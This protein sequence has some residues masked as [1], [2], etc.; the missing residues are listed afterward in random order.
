MPN[1]T[2]LACLFESPHPEL[3]F[4]VKGLEVILHDPDT[5]Q[6]LPSMK[7]L[8]IKTL[9]IGFRSQ[10]DTLE[11]MNQMKGLIASHL[12]D[13]SSSNPIY[14]YS[15]VAMLVIATILVSTLLRE[16]TCCIQ[17]LGKAVRDGNSQ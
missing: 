13:L 15:T 11:T 2:N 3:V 9:I 4:K 6:Q 7:K 16:Y 10:K 14:K 8:T 1:G 17:L 12:D 5:K